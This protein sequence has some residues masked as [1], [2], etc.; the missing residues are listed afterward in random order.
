M[1]HN[2]KTTVREGL[3]GSGGWPGDTFAGLEV[4]VTGNPLQVSHVHLQYRLALTAVWIG[5]Q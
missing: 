1:T 4:R 5:R 2:V 3:Q